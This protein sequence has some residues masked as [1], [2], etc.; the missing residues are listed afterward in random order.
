MPSKARTSTLSA[1]LAAT[2]ALSALAASPCRASDAAAPKPGGVYPLTPGM[3]V[4]EGSD[5]A[6]AANA[7]LRQYDGKGIG[8][9]H[10]HACRVKIRTRTGDTYVVDQS[11][12]DAGVGPA[13]RSSERQTIQVSDARTFVQTVGKDATTYHYCPAP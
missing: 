3:Y 5:C 2:L 4:A 11:C 1:A 13:P 6:S 9:A 10:T 12:I 8:S 7:A